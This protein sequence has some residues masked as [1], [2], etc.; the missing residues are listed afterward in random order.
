MMKITADNNNL[1]IMK[2]IG[3]RVKRSRL[4]MQLTQKELA[5]RAGISARTLSTIE[6]SGD[7]RLE[8]LIRVFR[9]MGLV[10]NLNVLL[11]ELEF[12]PE[13]YRTL[14]KSR[15]RVS[16]REKQEDHSSGWKWGDEE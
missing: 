5:Q 4:D 11:P 13:D 9:A 10:D 3:E 15:Q 1:A 16:K 12:N 14:G 6:N 7:V 2:E 8:I